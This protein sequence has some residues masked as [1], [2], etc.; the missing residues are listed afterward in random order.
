L[1]LTWEICRKALEGAGF[2]ERGY[3][4]MTATG[5]VCKLKAGETLTFKGREYLNI[6]RDDTV[7]NKTK[8]RIPTVGGSL[9][10]EII[11]E[12]ASS[13]IKSILKIS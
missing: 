7:R 10:L 4:G 3:F 11:K 9:T 5:S 8:E 13:T 2:V 12:V 6:V 1:N